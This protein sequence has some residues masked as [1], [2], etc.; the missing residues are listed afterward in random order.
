MQNTINNYKE[1]QAL[2][3]SFVGVNNLTPG[4]AP[5]GAFWNTLTY[6][7]FITGDVPNLGVPILVVGN[8]AESNL[9]QVLK[10]T[11]SQFPPMPQPNPPYN[12]KTPTQDVVISQISAWID[13]DCP[14]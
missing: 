9:I 14:N 4:L 7:Q 5:H 2:L 11:S 8:S 1:L 13:A 6:E 3:N 10:G 12:A